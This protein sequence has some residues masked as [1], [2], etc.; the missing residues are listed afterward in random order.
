MI[1]RFASLMAVVLGFGLLT[2]SAASAADDPGSA[3]ATAFLNPG[4]LD[5]DAELAFPEILGHEDVDLYREIFDVQVAGDWKT[6]D[7]LI[8]RLRDR[9]LMGHVMAQ[10]Y[11]HPT[12]YRS[13]YKELKA[14]MA[15]YA[16]HPDAR[17]LY[18]LALR[19]KPKNWRAPKPLAHTL[20]AHEDAARASGRRIPFEPGHRWLLSL[21]LCHVGGLA[22]LFRALVSG[23]AIALP[24]SETTLDDAL[25]RLAPT[26]VSLVA[27]QLRRLL[28]VP[29][30]PRALAACE[31][32]LIGG[33]PV[34]AHLV[35]RARAEGI[36]LRQTYGCTE[37][38]SQ[39]CT[40]TPEDADTCGRPLDGYAVKVDDTG[41][42]WARGPG[43]AAG[44]IDEDRLVSLTDA[45][46]W[47]ATGDL[48]A[49]DDDG[50]LQVTGRVDNLFIS[51]GENIQ[52]EEVERLLAEAGVD[53]VV[54]DVPDDAYGAR[55]V[56]FS[57]AAV[58]VVE[59]AANAHLPGFMRPIAVYPLPTQTG[60]KVSRAI[61]RQEAR[62]RRR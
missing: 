45:D 40:S 53:V 51:G 20:E 32:V 2:G 33:G 6:A 48:G 12:K 57:A 3:P 58:D 47:Y 28:E 21:P 34:G 26:H 23:A 56:A 62:R 25:A 13:K 7:T 35:A 54:V 1:K 52:P 50:R 60:L 10:R 61:L 30:A 46:G 16:D 55:P 19:R 36:S 15:K 59:A 17:Q 44:R 8:A 14:W 9:V 42:I 11:L 43:L 38:G 5:A 4:S 29:A 24:A 31:T 27:T 22:I 39:I 41:Q 37:L 18:K 49:L